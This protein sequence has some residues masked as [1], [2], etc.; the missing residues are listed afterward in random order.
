[1]PRIK[2]FYEEATQYARQHEGQLAETKKRIESL[3]ELSKD[4]PTLE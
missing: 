1:V 2:A 4:L 3:T